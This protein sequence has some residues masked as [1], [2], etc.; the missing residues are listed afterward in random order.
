VKDTSRDARVAHVPI[1]GGT[2]KNQDTGTTLRSTCR[3]HHACDTTTDNRDVT[4]Q[5]FNITHC[6]SFH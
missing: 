4:P 1:L 2:L 3:R 5:N 6:T